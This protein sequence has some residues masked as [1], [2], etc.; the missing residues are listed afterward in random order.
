MA[1]HFQSAMFKSLQKKLFVKSPKSSTQGGSPTSKSVQSQAIDE[2]WLAVQSHALAFL[3]P[4]VW[5]EDNICVAS[6]CVYHL[7]LSIACCVLVWI[8]VLN[9]RCV[10]PENGA[11]NSHKGKADAKRDLPAPELWFSKVPDDILQVDKWCA[12]RHLAYT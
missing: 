12:S 8:S 3:D 4:T 5:K 9:L 2:A 10:Q 1:S 11:R 7:H 6:A